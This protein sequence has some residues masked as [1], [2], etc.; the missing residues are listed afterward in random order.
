MR[1]LFYVIGPSGAGKDSLM[2][3]ARHALDGQSILFAHRYITRAASDASESFVQLSAAEFSLRQRLGLFWLVWSSHHL[4]YAV[5]TEVL[6]WLEADIPVV[7]NGSRQA[8]PQVIAA[9]AQAHIPLVPVWVHCELSVL[10]QR[11]SQRG[12]ESHVQIEERLQRAAQFEPPVG[13]LVIDNSGNLADALAQWMPH[14]Q[15]VLADAA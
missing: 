11:L 9:C 4:A 13:A 10:A 14:L 6:R 3:A 8:L 1:C 2:L 15:A 12:R 7:V 5:G